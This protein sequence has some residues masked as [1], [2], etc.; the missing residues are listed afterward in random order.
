MNKY[1]NFRDWV[2]EDAEHFIQQ[3][4]T[5]YQQMSFDVLESKAFALVDA[6]GTDPKN[7]IYNSLQEIN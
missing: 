1:N 3:Y 5:K 4:A 2:P 7:W 6:L